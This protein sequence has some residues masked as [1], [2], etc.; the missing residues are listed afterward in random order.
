MAEWRERG[1]GGWEW[2]SAP[3]EYYAT[4]VW[5][6]E[7]EQQLAANEWWQQA[8]ENAR[9][10]IEFQ[11]GLMWVSILYAM[12][13]MLAVKLNEW[14]GQRWIVLAAILLSFY[15]F[16]IYFGIEAADECVAG[17]FVERCNRVRA[18]EKL[19]RKWKKESMQTCVDNWSSTSVKGKLKDIFTRLISLEYEYIRIR[20]SSIIKIKRSQVNHSH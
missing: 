3:G 13:M 5:R 20:K 6:E 19:V 2:R 7:R 10:V 4:P 18:D 9:C 16:V 12:M 1:T 15:K 11:I 14:T 8:I 17:E